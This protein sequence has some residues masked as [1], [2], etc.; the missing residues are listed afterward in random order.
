[1]KFYGNY[2]YFYFH[3]VKLLLYTDD[4][5]MNTKHLF[6]GFIKIISLIIT[7]QSNTFKANLPYKLNCTVIQLVKSRTSLIFPI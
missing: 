3:F 5:K 6:L 2:Y 4:D 7:E 1:M